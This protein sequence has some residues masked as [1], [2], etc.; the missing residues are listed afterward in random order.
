MACAAARAGN[1][2]DEARLSLEAAML[3]DPDATRKKAR[4]EEDF[5]SRR[6]AEWFQRLIGS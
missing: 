3:R 1:M 4:R 2:E 5:A 6:D